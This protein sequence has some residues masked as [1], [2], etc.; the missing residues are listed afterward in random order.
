VQELKTPSVDALESVISDEGINNHEKP[1]L[2]STE[3]KQSTFL[4]SIM[5]RKWKKKLSKLLSLNF[6]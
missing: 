4:S 2:Y 1:F 5:M 3:P 6:L